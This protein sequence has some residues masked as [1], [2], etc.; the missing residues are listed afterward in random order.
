MKFAAIA[1]VSTASAISV[2]GG[3][4]DA[5]EASAIFNA[6]DTNGNGQVGKKELVAALN[7]FA[8]SRDYK[9]TK[10]DW[11]WVAKTAYA[12][13]GADKTLSEA[14]FAKWVN[15]FAAHFQIDGCK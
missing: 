13:A 7:A 10:A 9:P 5:K 3:C 14:E 12:D 2:R 15:Q 1:L 4:V 8:K 11:A 6:I